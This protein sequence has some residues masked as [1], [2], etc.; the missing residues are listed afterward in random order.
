MDDNTTRSRCTRRPQDADQA[1]HRGA[2]RRPR[3]AVRVV[4]VKAEAASGRL[5]PRHPP[6][7][8]EGDRQAALRGQHPAVRGS[9]LMGI[10]SLQADLRRP[11]LH[12]GLGLRG[13]HRAEP[14]KCLLAPGQAQRRPQQQRPHHD[15]PP[16]RRAQ[17]PL[18]DHRLQAP[19][20][21]RAGQGRLD[22][23]RPEPLDAHRAAALR[24][25]REGLHPGAAAAAGRRDGPVRRR[26]RHQA[27]QRLPLSA[28]PTGT[29]VHA[30]ELRPGQGAK[31][32]P[33]RRRQRAA[34]RQGGRQGAPAPAL[35]RAP[36]RLGRV[37]RGHRP[38]VATRRTRTSPAARPAARAGWASAR[39]CAAP[40]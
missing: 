36:P 28:I 18:P 40:R 24:R 7:L 3:R 32:V 25:R 29:T 22:R 17:A 13:D 6:R 12:D 15:A 20:G 33:L 26:R 35:R 38:A 8:Q 9:A 39:P 19:Q 4:N 34:G 5:L 14:E 31:M 16:G 10:R 37:P 2:L 21:R 30:I 1:G 23:V 27:G 11:S